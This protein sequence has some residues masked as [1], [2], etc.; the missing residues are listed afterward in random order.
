MHIENLRIERFGQLND[1]CA[2]GL[3]RQLNILL[4][5]GDT[6]RNNARDFLRWLLFG[7]SE[8]SPAE[9]PPPGHFD[10]ALVAR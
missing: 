8:M 2:N 4:C 1:A 3:H 6:E 9:Y 7:T 5:A 10:V